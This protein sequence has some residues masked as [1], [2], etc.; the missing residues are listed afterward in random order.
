LRHALNLA[1]KKEKGA[2]A[3]GQQWSGVIWKRNAQ[4]CSTRGQRNG[5][6]VSEKGHCAAARHHE[7]FIEPLGEQFEDLRMRPFVQE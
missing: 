4:G 5:F 1:Q 3:H 7:H 2:R 6:R